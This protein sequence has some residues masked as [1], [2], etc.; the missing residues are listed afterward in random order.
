MIELTIDV[1]LNPT[2]LISKKIIMKNI[3]NHTENFNHH[4]EI[5]RCGGRSNENMDTWTDCEILDIYA[6]LKLSGNATL[7]SVFDRKWTVNGQF[8]R[9]WTVNGQFDRKWTVE[10]KIDNIQHSV[11][12]NDEKWTNRRYYM[13]R[14]IVPM[15]LS[16][17]D[18]IRR[19][20]VEITT[21]IEIL[22]KV[23]S[24]V[25]TSIHFSSANTWRPI[26]DYLKHITPGYWGRLPI[27]LCVY[28]ITT[29]CLLNQ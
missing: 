29:T 3:I 24:W 21:S 28:F 27:Y 2:T 1:V 16:N 13:Q 9:K 15:Y 5:L 11:N 17:R 25:L 23:E 19:K 8:D 4:V 22:L 7:I 14:C 20:V 12:W 26:T 18:I 6:I 10:K